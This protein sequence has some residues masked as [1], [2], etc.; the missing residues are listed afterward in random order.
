M[1]I[2]CIY[3]IVKNQNQKQDP[4]PKSVSGGLKT[5]ALILH[6]SAQLELSSFTSLNVTTTNSQHSDL[7]VNLLEDKVVTQVVVCTQTQ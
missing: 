4:Q 3:R 2:L 6:V 5:T 1:L 7:Q